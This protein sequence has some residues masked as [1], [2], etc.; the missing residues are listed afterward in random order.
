MITTT[1]NRKFTS[2]SNSFFRLAEER[3]QQ[4]RKQCFKSFWT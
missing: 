3:T 4:I 1:A 2:V